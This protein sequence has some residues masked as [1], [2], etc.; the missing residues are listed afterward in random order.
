MTDEGEGEDGGNHGYFTADEAPGSPTSEH[1]L[2][3]LPGGGSSGFQADYTTRRG[4]RQDHDVMEES[5]G[6]NSVIRRDHV[7]GKDSLEQA[8][9]TGNN[10]PSP[11]I[12]HR[13][14][15]ED[16]NLSAPC[17]TGL[18]GMMGKLDL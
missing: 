15:T 10:F 8:G 13:P 17:T 18:K 6:E 2:G 4:Y 11:Q 5:Q 3:G 14:A 16:L 9:D 1:E 12:T 7:S